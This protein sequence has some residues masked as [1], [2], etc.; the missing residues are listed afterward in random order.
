MSL[1][2]FATDK[3]LFVLQMKKNILVCFTYHDAAILHLLTSV[4]CLSDVGTVYRGFV[5][6]VC[7]LE[8]AGELHIIILRREGMGFF[9]PRCYRYK[10]AITIIDRLGLYPDSTI[11]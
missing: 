7:F 6:N 3:Y 11:P 5:V 1:A 8:R 9:I 10:E 4:N 2:G